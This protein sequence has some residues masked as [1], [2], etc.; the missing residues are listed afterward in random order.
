MEKRPTIHLLMPFYIDQAVWRL[1]RKRRARTAPPGRMREK[2]GKDLSVGRQ[3][4]L[5]AKSNL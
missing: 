3:G 5:F 4:T 2:A 1:R